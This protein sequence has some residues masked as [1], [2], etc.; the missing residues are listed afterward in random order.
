MIVMMHRFV[1][2]QKFFFLESSSIVKDNEY[3]GNDNDLVF[4]KDK[5][6]SH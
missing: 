2:H 1:F 4:R 5:S 3:D 6:D